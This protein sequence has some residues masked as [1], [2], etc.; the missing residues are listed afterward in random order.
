MAVSADIK[1]M[2]GLVPVEGGIALDPFKTTVDLDGTLVRFDKDIDGNVIGVNLVPK[3]LTFNRLLRD[4][5]HSLSI[6]TAAFYN[7]VDAFAAFFPSVSAMFDCIYTRE[8]LINSDAPNDSEIRRRQE[9]LWQRQKKGD[10]ALEKWRMIEIP[11]GLS[12]RDLAI[13]NSAA[14]QRGKVPALVG[15]SCMVDDR[16]KIRQIGDA[17]TRVTVV[18]PRQIPETV[19]EITQYIK[20]RLNTTASLLLGHPL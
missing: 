3:V 10:P 4:M 7:R 19:E 15:S 8:S 14:K 11:A 12:V 2:W 16:N 13:I 1:T 17:S 9:E 5:G 18:H 6:Y 20:F